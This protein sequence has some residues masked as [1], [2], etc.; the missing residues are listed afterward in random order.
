MG[1]ENG[2]I[3]DLAAAGQIERFQA[4]GFYRGKV[5]ACQRDAGKREVFQ[6]LPAFQQRKKL[7]GRKVRQR[8][9]T[10]IGLIRQG[11]KVGVSDGN[12]TIE[13]EILQVRP[14]CYVTNAISIFF[15]L[16]PINLKNFE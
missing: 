12:V 11:S 7:L 3:A 4:V 2:E 15:Q 6:L 1:G 14:P 8:C 9:Q 10:D 5:F 13:A 16:I